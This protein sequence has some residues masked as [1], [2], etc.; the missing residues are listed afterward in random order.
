MPT[1]CDASI[2]HHRTIGITGSLSSCIMYA[3]QYCCITVF[4]A[5]TA[6][7]CINMACLCS[8]SWTD[9]FYRLQELPQQDHFHVR[10]IFTTLML[11]KKTTTST[12]TLRRPHAR[13]CRAS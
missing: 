6:K 7:C 10:N 9:A 3:S 5:I 12:S 8:R 1:H 4:P 11:A 13:A 2:M